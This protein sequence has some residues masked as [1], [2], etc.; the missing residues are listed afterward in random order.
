MTPEDWKEVE[1]KLDSLFDHVELLID[2]YKVTYRLSRTGKTKLAI[3]TYVNG[4]WK[5]AYYNECEESKRF[6]C[7]KN[8]GYS[9]KY[10]TSMKKLG[11][12][13]LKESG[14]DLD[15]TTTLYSPLW[16]SF[17]R[18]KGHLIKNN[19]SIELIR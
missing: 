4:A 7:P 5:G 15:R 14:I 11:K 1:K 17:K 8:I 6:A 2:G 12:R 16:P 10:K 3:M 19:T 9:R 13:F 18:L